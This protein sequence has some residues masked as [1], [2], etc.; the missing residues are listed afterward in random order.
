MASVPSSSDVNYRHYRERCI[1]LPPVQQ[2]TATLS[3]VDH[4]WPDRHANDDDTSVKR[5]DLDAGRMDFADEGTG[6]RL[7]L[8]R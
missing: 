3:Q 2:F 8:M 6:E 5:E 4:F 7:P 1:G